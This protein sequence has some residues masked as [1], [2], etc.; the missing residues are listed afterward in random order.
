[1]NRRAFLKQAAMT[2]GAAFSLPLSCS[3]FKR[4]PPTPNILFL[5]ADDQS[6]EALSVFGS[7]VQT[8][9]LDRLA[10]AGVSFR[11]AYNQGGWHG[12][13][14]VASRTMLITGRFLGHAQRIEPQLD[15][16]LAAGRLWP[17][18]L[19]QAG[20][21][22]YF[23]G[24]WHVKVDAR[25]VFQTARHIRPGMPRDTKAGYLRP[26]E[27]EP[28]VW[29]PWDTLLGGYWEGGQHWSE[30]LREDAKAFINQA[31]Q[32]NKP[33][34]MY[35]AFNA[36]HDPRQSPQAYVNRYPL[37]QLKIP[38]NFMTEYPFND[39]IG[40]SI[41]LR[42]ERLAPLPRTEYAVK[43]HRQ[44]YYAIISHLDDQIGRI[45][46]ALEKSGKA[47]NTYI[48][49]TADNGLALGRHGL[50][51]KQNMFE[52]S[53]KVPLILTGPNIPDNRQ[54]DTPVYLQ[55]LM[56]TTL[57]LAGISIPEQ[58]QFRSLMPLINGKRPEHYEAIYGGYI[59]L[60]RMVRKGDFKLIYYP[61][62]KKTLL[63]NLKHDPLEMNDLATD[64]QYAGKVIELKQALVA[65]QKQV[66]DTLELNWE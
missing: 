21:E 13:V 7:E 46:A 49:F 64:E 66:G 61:K 58:V 28:D 59:D 24:K 56:P 20:Y 31:A 47:K 9:N 57:E 27:G 50:F 52:H 39:E 62:I 17:Q 63:F 33:F 51:G 60:Q 23:S 54:I 43:V 44:E 53:M 55:D 32:S 30:V 12:A 41:D 15:Q 14:C 45:L 34:F 5:F 35:L 16:E 37:D 6:H 38:E 29:C 1:M 48:L 22:T 3:L 42:D 40:C 10:S 65:L 11:N 4:P 36:P 8:P 18:Y 19:A 25:Q 2:T 26:V